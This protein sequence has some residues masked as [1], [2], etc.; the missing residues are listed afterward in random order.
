MTNLPTGTVTFLFTDIEGSTQLWE[1]H[2]DEMRIAL[3]KHDAILRDA[4]T[5]HD[6]RIIK[7]TGDGAHAV[8]E[9]AID[10]IHTT[11]AIQREIAACHFFEN[12]EATLR[13]RIGLHTGEAELRADD[14][15]GQALNRVARIMSVAYGGQILVSAITS[16]VVREHL[17]A[18][19][20]LLDLGEH[21]LKDLVRP[22]HIFQINS[23]DLQVEFPT[24]NTL[25]TI[26]NNLPLQL[27]SFIG[28]EKEIEEI[29][30]L[31]DS[32]RMVTLTGSGGTGKTRLALEVGT[33]LVPAFAH[34]VWL[35]ELAPLTDP[36]QMIPALAQVFGLQEHPFGPLNMLLTDYL[37]DKKILLLLDNCEH[38]IEACAH[39]ANDLLHQCAGLKI[40][41]SSRE[42]LG[43]AGE[44]AYHI[45]SLEDSE[46]RRLF[47]E[48][49]RAANP[50]FDPTDSN[51]SS[52]AQICSRLDGIPLA[53][54][55]AA[56]RVKLL[57]PEQIA[58]RLDDRFRLL[59]G[60]SRTALP[61]QQTLRAMIDW[62]YDLLSDAE[63]R[64]LQF[65]SVFVGGWTLDALEAV[66]DGPDTLEHLEQLINKSLV[67]TEERGDQMRYFM[68]ETIRQYA[69]EK[70]FDA[71]QASAA[72][73]R[74]YVYFDHLSETIWKVFQTD[75]IHVWR[76]QADD[77]MDNLRAAVE[78][79]LENHLEEAIR[80]AGNFCMVTGWMGIRLDEGLALC[81]SAI[82]R[83]RA[84][85]VV[86]GQANIERQKSLSR[87]LFAQGMV[88]LSH[89]NMPIVI[90]DLQD[91]IATARAAGDKRM[92]GYSLEM[93]YTATTFMQ[94]PG[95]EAAAEEGFRIF[96]EEVNDS[97]GLSMAY[98]NR[99][100]IAAAN[101]DQAEKEKYLAKYKEL[102]RQA[103]LSFQAG[104]FYLGTGMDENIHGNYEAAKVLFE[105]GLSVFNQI[106]NWNF[107]LIMTSELGHNARHTGKI[108]EAKKI[109]RETLKGWQNMGNRA[110]MANQLEC[111]A[112][113]A[114]T[115]E[116]PQR[117]AILF[118]A[119]EYLR[120][121]V[122]SP[123]TDYEQ[124]EY[125]R[126][127]SRLRSMLPESDFNNFWA[128]GRSM[129]MEQV[130]EFALENT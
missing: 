97:W 103:P 30:K 34:G 102:I 27:T 129:S 79:G 44:V 94:V 70:L 105:E 74:H 41:A 64:L 33:Q 76:D 1:N 55:L 78:W 5:A 31:V 9:K 91:A 65:A 53:I 101:G 126:S 36:S 29:R 113:I 124:V 98:Q 54:E 81:R 2:P 125:D 45:P 84:L 68:L 110:A 23:P 90:Q 120:D 50:K 60:G 100:R 46:S 58:D 112:F 32:N 38:L 67:L 8:F 16:E 92:L 11:L 3:A 24:L 69:R 63:K 43:I 17:P 111:F 22:E 26:P 7:T 51:A 19:I 42:S 130:I 115:E 15:Y 89:G 6:G 123:M 127:I 21:R 119:A 25:N 56:A 48:R 77:E 52:I 39:L 20:T 35:I 128:E 104:L 82:D 106:R 114:I 83:I 59:V 109:Y 28:R 12:P 13:V 118:G 49:A 14:Y 61:R 93:F 85:P 95:A 66:A 62:S 40:L 4:I 72:R 116:K 75:N 47:V 73:D 37:R 71:K 122:Q 10:A 121:K 88:G 18:D 87:A 86:D 108:S 117:A 57:S 99:A 107:Q 96:T 80:L